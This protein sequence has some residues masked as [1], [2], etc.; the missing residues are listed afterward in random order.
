MFIAKRHLLAF[1]SAS[2]LAACGGSGGS[3]SGSSGSSS[4]GSSSG[5]GSSGGSSAFTCS[6]VGGGSATVSSSCV[7]CP[8]NAATNARLAIDTNLE[9]AAGLTLFNSSDVTAQ[10][11]QISLRGTAQ[12]GIIFPAGSKAGLIIGLPT[13]QS[14]RY[15]ATVNTYLSGTQQETRNVVTGNTGATNGEVRYFGF[16]AASPTTRNFDAVEISITELTPGAE[17]HDYRIFE[18]CS[19]GVAR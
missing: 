15:S 1:L 14:V 19:D 2:L 18:F 13:G 11:G 9:T 10:Q 7:S 5:G 8:S 16:T 6:P 17:R 4:G 12:S 3:S